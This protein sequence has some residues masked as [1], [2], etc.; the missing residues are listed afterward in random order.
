[1]SSV[2]INITQD[3]NLGGDEDL[4]ITR[5]IIG[6]REPVRG[7]VKIAGHMFDPTIELIT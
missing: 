4:D 3:Q 6:S 7:P 5:S 2:T 1:V